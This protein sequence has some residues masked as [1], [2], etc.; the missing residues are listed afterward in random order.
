MLIVINVL[1]T[2][3]CKLFWLFQRDLLENNFMISSSYYL[4]IIA[5]CFSGAWL[6]EQ[7]IE[8]V[9]QRCSVKKVFLEISQN[10]QE[11][12]CARVSFLVKLQALACSF[13]KKR[14]WRRCSL[15]NFVKFLRTPF[16]IEQLRWEAYSEPC[17]TSKMDL[18]AEILLRKAPSKI[19]DR[20]LNTSLEYTHFVYL[21]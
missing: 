10:S 15:V 11:K 7:Y 8:A 20:V 1:L 13:A 4:G 16:Y 9:V 14:L 3:L 12:T 6:L 19:F 17:Q 2:D 21:V 5:E 18:F